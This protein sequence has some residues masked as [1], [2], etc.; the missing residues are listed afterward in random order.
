MLMKKSQPSWG[1]NMTE[2]RRIIKERD[3]LSDA[4]FDDLLYEVYDKTGDDLDD[5]LLEVFGIEPDYIFDLIEEL[6][7]YDCP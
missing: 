1:A 6:N 2:L 4:E 3:G 7:A 5:T